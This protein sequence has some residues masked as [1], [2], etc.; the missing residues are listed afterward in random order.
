MRYQS[1]TRA[2]L[3]FLLG[4]GTL[5]LRAHDAHGQPHEAQQMELPN[6]DVEFQLDGLGQVPNGPA[7]G[8]A[9]PQRRQRR[10]LRGGMNQLGNLL[11]AQQGV[12]TPEAVGEAIHEPFAPPMTANKIRRAIDDAAYFLRTQQSADGAIGEGGWGGGGPT[13]LATLA[14]LAAGGNPASDP[15]LQRA[16]EWLLEL[17]P[18]NTYVRGIRANVWEYALRKVPYDGRLRAALREDFDWLLAALGD[19][20]GWRY[21]KQSSDWDNSCT[22][23]GVL[24]IWAGER[25][26]LQAGA[27]FWERM[28]KHFRSVQNEDGGWGYMRGGSTAN[29]A[30]AG[31]AS[32]FLVFDMHHG[33]SFYAA[34]KPRSFEQGPASEALKAIERGM[35]WL[36]HSSDN[37]QHSYYLYGIERT[38]VASGRKRIGGRDWFA[39]GALPVLTR[40]A[41]NGAISMGYSAVISTSLCTLFLVYGGAPVVFHKLDYGQGGEWNLNPR[42]LANLSKYLWSAYERPVNWQ[43]VHIDAGSEEFEAPVLFISGNKAVEFTE[44]QVARLR[45]YVE[46]GG[47]ILA[48][49]SDHSAEFRA[50]M[51]T[52]LGRMYPVDEYPGVRL[53]P[54]P[55]EHGVYTVLRQHWK[56]RP[57]LQGAGDGA[58]TFFFL[59]EGYLSADWQMNMV[60][61]EAFQIAMNLLFYA[62]DMAT[63]QG[64]FASDLA[65]GPAAPE[66]GALRV[67]RLKVGA[68]GPHP[69]DWDAAS[70]TWGR[71]A[72]HLL[73][74]AGLSIEELPPVDLHD[75]IPAAVR[76][77][78]L[79]GRRDFRLDPHEQR[80]LREWVTGGGTLL[81]DAWGGSQDFAVAARRELFAA[82]VD[83]QP[84]TGDSAVVVGR[85][86]GG[87]DLRQRVRF[88]LPARR[89]L[90]RK[91]AAPERHTLEVAHLG[92]AGAVYF[93]SFDLSAGVAGV[94]VYGAL[95]YKPGSARRV[96]TNL[97][98]SLPPTR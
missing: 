40:Q 98:A 87:S 76:V 26:G 12:G 1:M 6:G 84:L 32:M 11:V 62:T 37:R 97:V 18:D 15:S 10:Q 73:H 94:P 30:T 36:A 39:D 43:T 71:L 27:A 56:D 72:P 17:K 78:H 14:L 58:R 9:M 23:Y 5:G 46:R 74:N 93:S 90:R 63:P 13:A 91:G 7:V 75:G 29:M 60:E 83:L 59:S 82:G 95:G 81:V 65:E 20:E 35:D 28:S 31:L 3:F 22:Q 42:D 64:R 49:P 77:V 25:A 24:G 88:K 57:A 67:A 61:S 48:E 52:L 68:V 96:M 54:L 16:I 38:G 33:R 45:A 66:R 85:F 47:T 44:A 51:A 50:S 34:S 19:S 86:P 41:P 79:S 2:G 21:N 89:L 55:A 92:D 4:I 70:A 69:M 80:V 53:E 8:R